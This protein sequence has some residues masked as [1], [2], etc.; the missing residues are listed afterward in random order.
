MVV[1]PCRKE[2]RVARVLKLV[3][4]DGRVIVVKPVMLVALKVQDTQRRVVK[5][6]MRR[7]DKLQ[8]LMDYYS[9]TTTWCALP[10]PP[11]AALGS[12]RFV[13]DSKRL[14][15]ES[16][17]EDLGMVNGDKIDFFEDLMS[18]RSALIS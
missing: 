7:T 14:K 15:G 6:T 5:R 10:V 3:D 2:E 1:S 9:T 13:F 11:R 18:G 16:T 4:G 17:P 12:G 8:G